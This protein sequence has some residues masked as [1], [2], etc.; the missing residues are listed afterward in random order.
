MKTM[1]LLR[2][3]CVSYFNDDTGLENNKKMSTE[4]I[5]RINKVTI[6]RLKL[7]KVL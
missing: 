3:P 1:M 4:T 6:K 5:S 7:L 2:V